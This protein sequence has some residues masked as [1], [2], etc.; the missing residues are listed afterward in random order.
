MIKRNFIETLKKNMRINLVF[1]QETKS[2]CKISNVKVY[3]DKSKRGVG[4][5]SRQVIS[6]EIIIRDIKR[7]K[8]KAEALQQHQMM[9]KDLDALEGGVHNKIAAMVGINNFNTFTG[10]ALKMKTNSLNS[11][12]SN[13]H[14]QGY[15]SQLACKLGAILKINQGD[16]DELARSSCG[17]KSLCRLKFKFQYKRKSS[18]NRQFPLYV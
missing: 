13:V 7:V 17:K 14:V 10:M 8:D 5:L 1:C 6:A 12:M 16:G 4:D 11:Q 9:V 3:C 2:N 15:Q 18:F